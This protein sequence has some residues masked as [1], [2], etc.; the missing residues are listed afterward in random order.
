MNRYLLWM[1]SAAGLGI[2]A[3]CGSEPP[4]AKPPLPVVSVAIP[5]AK[6]VTD[7]EDF[8][9]NTDAVSKVDIRAG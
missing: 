8:T 9:G 6:E 3:G 5:V 4:P 7:Y 1:L 2:L